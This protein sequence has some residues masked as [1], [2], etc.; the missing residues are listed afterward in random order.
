MRPSSFVALALLL[1]ASPSFAQTAPILTFGQPPTVITWQRPVSFG[2]PTEAKL[3]VR[4]CVEAPNT[5][6]ICTALPRQVI[7]S[8]CTTALQTVSCRVSVA[9]ISP[10]LSGLHEIAVCETYTALEGSKDFC[11][12]VSDPVTNAPRRVRA[13]IG[14]EPKTVT[15]AAK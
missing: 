2:T 3:E 15:V 12:D 13:I 11:T 9:V 6:T 4:N 10:T 1:C 5:P 14:L 8:T 7:T